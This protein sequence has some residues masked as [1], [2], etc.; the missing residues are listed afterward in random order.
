MAREAGRGTIP[1]TAFW[2]PADREV[3]E[4]YENARV[5]RCLLDLPVAPENEVMPILDR[6]AR[7]I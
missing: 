3:I 2:A 6:Y 1:V 7:L 5:E 4:N